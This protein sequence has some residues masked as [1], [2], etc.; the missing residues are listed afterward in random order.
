MLKAQGWY[1]K[2]DKNVLLILINRGEFTSLMKEIKNIDPRAFMSVTST[3]SVYGE[4]FEEI[5]G[6]VNDAKSMLKKGKKN[7]S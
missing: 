2:K 7:E 4:G 5:K 6:G 1:T 3:K